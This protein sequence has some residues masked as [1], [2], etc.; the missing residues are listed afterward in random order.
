MSFDILT[1]DVDGADL[2]KV[3]NARNYGLAELPT[4]DQKDSVKE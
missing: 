1:V 2:S 3:M 4:D